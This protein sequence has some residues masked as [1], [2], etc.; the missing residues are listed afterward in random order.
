MLATMQMNKADTKSTTL[1]DKP[2]KAATTSTTS[3][4]R[5]SSSGS[6]ASFGNWF[7][8]LQGVKAA[9]SKERASKESSII[10]FPAQLG[11]L[12]DYED[13][14]GTINAITEN[15]FSDRIF[16]TPLQTL[17]WI[18]SFCHYTKFDDVACYMLNL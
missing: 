9:N 13:F 7:Q 8:A 14:K 15:R 16:T 17:D 12:N 10:I 4:S 11:G 6:K 5:S 2:I 1:P 18:V 3:S